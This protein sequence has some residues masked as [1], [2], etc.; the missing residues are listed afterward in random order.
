MQN[1]Q[2]YALLFY[3]VGFYTWYVYK[4]MQITISGYQE[5][6][7]CYN[8]TREIHGSRFLGRTSVRVYFK[9]NTT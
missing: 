8:S 3:L 1:M 4:T 9:A 7:C 2:R 5:Q 6:N